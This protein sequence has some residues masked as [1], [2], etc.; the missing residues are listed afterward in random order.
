MDKAK[1]NT[2][3]DASE[4][5]GLTKDEKARVERFLENPAKDEYFFL[6]RLI[7]KTPAQ[8]RRLMIDEFIQRFDLIKQTDEI[9]KAFPSQRSWYKL[10]VAI[11][12]FGGMMGVDEQ[13]QFWD[14]MRYVLEALPQRREFSDKYTDRQ[15]GATGKPKKGWD[16][17]DCLHC[18]RT[19][20]VNAG[21][22]R[23]SPAFCFEHDLPANHSL[24][25]RHKRLRENLSDEQRI[26]VEKLKAALPQSLS[27]EAARNTML[28]LLTSTNDCLPR[29]VEHL[30]RAGHDGQPESLLWA[31]HGPISDGIQPHY[32]EALGEF[33]RDI[34]TMKSPFEPYGPIPFIFTIPELSRAEA[35][36]TLL[37][38]DGRRKKG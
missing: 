26:I 36:L 5:Q 35:W 11:D 20:P 13:L 24:Y 31:F 33:I 27:D 4:L 8:V 16:F 37:D 19:V 2:F 3:L 29:L 9:E 34:L 22:S 10:D 38:R 18:W 6:L 21:R 15:V 28:S 14:K 12:E 17:R 1:V 30:A 7:G 23:K 25:R 32:K